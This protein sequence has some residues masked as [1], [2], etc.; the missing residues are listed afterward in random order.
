[1]KGILLAGGSGSRLH[2]VT[3]A[4]SKQLLPIYDKPMVHY[5]LAT[6]MLAGI[7]DILV[8][9]TPRDLPHYRELLGSGENLGIHLSFA[10][11]P[12]PGGLAQA[13]HIGAEFIGDDSVTMVLGDNL[14]HGEGLA[15][16]LQQA[17]RKNRGATVFGY[18]VADP[19]R[20]GVA[21]FDELGHISRIE[22]KPAQPPSNFAI[23]G[24]Y[25]YDN[26]VVR[27]SKGLK[28]SGRGEL[29]ITDVNNTYLEQGR[30]DL[31]RLSRGTAWLDTGTFDALLEAS[32]FMATLQHRTGLQVGCLPE[33]AW[34]MGFISDAELRATAQD[35]GPQSQYL[36]QLLSGE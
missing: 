35:H 12:K 27:I 23:T 28:P 17:I 10:E 7:K 9:S 3:K 2:P 25:V 15:T 29:E 32:S 19:Q 21:A 1:M 33:V 5:P 31:V 8:I 30:L 24:L 13:F 11:Q 26:D 34:R 22:E 18:R 20:Y 14:F 6:L 36:L 16:T 4:V